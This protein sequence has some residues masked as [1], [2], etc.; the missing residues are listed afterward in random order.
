MKIAIVN[1]GRQKSMA[2]CQ[3]RVSEVKTGRFLAQLKVPCL[4]IVYGS[5]SETLHLSY[6]G[7]R[8]KTIGRLRLRPLYLRERILL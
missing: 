4:D 5:G 2:R 7:S 8:L 3:T 6:L 1:R